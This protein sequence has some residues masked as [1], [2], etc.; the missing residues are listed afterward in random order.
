MQRRANNSP[1]KAAFM[2]HV[3]RPVS[4]T[5]FTSAVHGRE[6]HSS[7]DSRILSHIV[8][9][10]AA[11][12]ANH[13]ASIS[14]NAPRHDA[15]PFARRINPPCRGETTRA[16]HA[17]LWEAAAV[18]RTDRRR[19]RRRRQHRALTVVAVLAVVRPIAR[20]LRVPGTIPNTSSWRCNPW[21]WCL[22]SRRSVV[23]VW[24]LV[25]FLCFMHFV[26]K[27]RGNWRNRDKE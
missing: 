22:A 11:R 17:L 12:N 4:T 18:M 15:A 6:A 5:A 3:E 24:R 1:W 7:E 9:I 27:N 13:G 10:P 26:W 20:S 8:I 21:G 16:G 25:A 23:S 19:H 2:L 14:Q